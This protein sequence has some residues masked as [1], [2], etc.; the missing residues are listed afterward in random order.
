MGGH[1]P[2]ER[3]GQLGGDVRQIV[4]GGACLPRVTRGQHDLVVRGQ[5]LG[6]GPAVLRLVHRAPHRRVRGIH[7]TLGQPQ[8]RQAG[9]RPASPLAGLAVRLL[10]LRELAPQPVQLPQLVEG[11]A[12]G[13]VAGRTRELFAGPPGFLHGVGPRAVQPHELG[14]VHQALPPVGH[15]SGCA[16]HHRASAT[17]HCLARRRSNVS[18]QELITAQ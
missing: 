15:E 7:L 6:A 16:S 9:L 5:Q 8:Q 17:V 3:R 12:D 2:Q 10:G 18:W 11:P 4:G 1:G 13:R 14:P